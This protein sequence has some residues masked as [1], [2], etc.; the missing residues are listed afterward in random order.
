MQLQKLGG[1][2]SIILACITVIGIL[3]MASI[4]QGFDFTELGI[5]DPAKMLSAY[6]ASSMGFCAYYILEILAAILIFLV[7]LALEERMQ[8]D[9]PLLM[10][11]AVIAASAFATLFITTMIGG[12]FSNVLLAATNDM[13]AFR[14]FLVL[15]EFLG[16]SATFALGWGYLLI[17]WTAIRSR[18]LPQILGYIIILLGIGAVTQFAFTVSQFM[19]GYIIYTLLGF[20]VFIWLGIVFLRKSV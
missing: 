20:I 10:R 8:T 15:H 1:Y 11:I 6:Q 18:K 13:S 12:F 17:G 5:Y 3:I 14:V 2:A 9:A 4:F 7:F 16:A 19:L